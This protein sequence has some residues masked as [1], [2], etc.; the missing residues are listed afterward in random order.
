[1]AT[2]SPCRG[3]HS[4]WMSLGSNWS[5]ASRLRSRMATGSSTWQRRQ[6]SS[7]PWGTDPSQYAGKGKIFHDDF[8]GRFIFALLH[9][10]HI[11]LHIES[12]RAGQSTGGLV[13]L[14]NGKRPRDGLGI[15]FEGRFPVNQSLVIFTGERHRTDRG[16]IAARRALGRVDVAGGFVDRDLKIALRR[17]LPVPPR[18]R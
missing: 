2:L 8:Q 15:L 1:M 7:Q 12:G 9:H 10:L 18:R 13:R 6:A 5:A 3:R 16:A 4:I 14:L 17:R 11:S